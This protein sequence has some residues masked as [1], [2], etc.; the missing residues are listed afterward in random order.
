[1]SKRKQLLTWVVDRFGLGPIYDNALNRRVAKAPW[2]YGDGATLSM[3][4]GVLVATGVVMVLTYSP[5]PDHAYKS[6]VHITEKQTL[7]WFIRALHYWAAGFMVVMLFFHLFRQI[8]VAGYKSPREATWIFGALLFQA[9]IAMSFTGYLLRWDERSVHAI[10]VM[11]HM[12][13]RVPWFGDELVIFIQGGDEMGS[14]LLT[15]IYAVHVL[16]LPLTI[17][18]MTAYHIY[19]VMHHG[20]TSRLEKER[21][22]DT[23][24]QQKELYHQQADSETDGETFYP[25]TMAKSG[26]MSLV[27]FAIV[28]AF[29]LLVGPARLYDEANLT[30]YSFPVEEWWFWWYSA[31]IAM[32]PSW[33]AP[34]FVVLFPL[35][36]LL[37]MLALPFVDRGPK[38]GMRRRPLAVAIVAFCV[39]SLL[40]LS[41][42]RLRSGWTG[43]PSPVLP[44]VPEGVIL[45]E[46][47]EQGRQLFASFGCNTC[48]SIGATGRTVAIDLAMVETPKSR[49]EYRRYILRPPLE[50]AM[51]PYEGRITEDE[52]DALL[53]Y[54]HAAQ[55]FPRQI[56]R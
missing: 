14:L 2:Y 22:I 18:L 36:L 32:L 26:A 34:A 5:T 12:F 51:P 4:L 53:D 21:D 48:H 7:G 17:G 49:Q 24:L 37:A 40:G 15:R 13:N 38:R 28:L 27:V 29:T 33:L 50:I 8:L 43:W 55:N 10:R 41:A 45:S 42:L 31:L 3:L 39:M 52:L 30:N 35:L 44:P 11:L 16:I 19:L 6:V 47:A 25:E 46:R 9:V 54:V 20:I 23:V 1:M 56:S